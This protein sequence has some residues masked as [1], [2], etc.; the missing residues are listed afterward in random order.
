MLLG[1]QHDLWCVFGHGAA[2]VL[3]LSPSSFFHSCPF[4]AT[5]PNRH[6]QEAVKGLRSESGAAGAAP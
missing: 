2:T 1:S 5:S 6:A 4:F 3:L